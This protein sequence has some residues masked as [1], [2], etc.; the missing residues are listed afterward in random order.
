MRKA[1][2]L[3]DLVRI[4]G[5]TRTTFNQWVSRGYFQPLEEFDHG[6]PRH[7]TSEEVVAAAV[8]AQISALIGI[9]RASKILRRCG[10]PAEGVAH[11]AVTET[12]GVC[13]D[14]TA[15]RMAVAAAL[16]AYGR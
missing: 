3:S 9:T 8:L 7:F 14:I 2:Y 6:R 4:I 15:A 1:I 11:Y 16:P 13:V 12:S 5:V 10:I